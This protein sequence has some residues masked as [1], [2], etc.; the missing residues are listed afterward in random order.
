MLWQF[1]IH[2]LNVKNLQI[3]IENV[4]VITFFHLFVFGYL[5]LPFDTVGLVM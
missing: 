2:C 5:L 4:F 1:L 3:K